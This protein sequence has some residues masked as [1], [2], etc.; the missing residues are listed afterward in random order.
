MSHDDGIKKFKKTAKGG[1]FAKG[2]SGKAFDQLK[3]HTET[4]KFLQ[5]KLLGIGFVCAF[6]TE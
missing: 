4:G 2:S 1:L 5:E 3:E 6:R